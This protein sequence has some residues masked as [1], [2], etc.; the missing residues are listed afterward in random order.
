MDGVFARQLC[1]LTASRS[2]LSPLRAKRP[3][4]SPAPLPRLP[5]REGRGGGG[6]TR[7]PPGERCPFLP[8]SLGRSGGNGDEAARKLAEEKGALTT[9]EN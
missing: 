9:R 7:E 3:R 5:A 8:L 6:T 1:H 4:P 2:K